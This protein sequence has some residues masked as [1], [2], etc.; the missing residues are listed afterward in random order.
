MNGFQIWI[1]LWLPIIC[2][3]DDNSV[4][5]KWSWWKN[6]TKGLS[7]DAD[8]SSIFRLFWYLWSL[9]LIFIGTCNGELKSCITVRLVGGNISVPC[10]GSILSVSSIIPIFGFEITDF[11]RVWEGESVLRIFYDFVTIVFFRW[12]FRSL[13]DLNA[14]HLTYDQ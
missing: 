13:I 10:V 4:F 7:Y 2:E 1:P 11:I 3:N 14:L 9:R 12:I 5:R 6:V 8:N